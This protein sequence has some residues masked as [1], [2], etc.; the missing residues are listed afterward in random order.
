MILLRKKNYSKSLTT[1]LLLIDGTSFDITASEG[2]LFPA[3]GS[4]SP[5]RAALWDATKNSPLQDTTREIIEV[6]R[7]VDDTFTITL[8]GQEGTAAKEWPIGS[9]FMLTL[10]SGTVEEIEDEIALKADISHSQADSTITLSKIGTP[11]YATADKERD[12]TGS[13][14]VFIGGG[15]TD[16]GNGTITVAAGSGSIRATDALTSAALSVDWAEV[17]SLALDDGVV[18]YIYLEYNA[19][20]PQIVA[21][22]TERTDFNTNI[23]LGTVFR[24]GNTA[25]IYSPK[26]HYGGNHAQQIARRL[27]G[28]L[29]FSRVSG[30][31]LGEIGT[32]NI[33][34]TEGLFWE[35]LDN[36]KTNIGGFDS[37]G[38][39]RFS[40]YYRT[41]AAWT[42]VADQSQIDNVYYNNTAT[43]LV[44]LT[45]NRYGVHWVFLEADSHIIVV[46]GQGDYTLAL[47]QAAKVPAALPPLI[48]VHARLIGKIIIQKAASVFISVESAFIY[49]FEKA[50]AA[51]HNDLLNI[52]GGSADERYH[53]T[54]AQATIATQAAS[55]S[56]SGYL[57]S[58]DWNTFNSKAA[59]LSGTINEIAYFNSATTIASL[60]VATYPSLTELSYVKG[61]SSAI[62]T[63][64]GTK[65]A[66]ITFGTGVLT[67]LGVNVGSAG[68]PVLFNGA[69]G[70]PSSGTLTNCTALPIAGLTASTSTALGVGSLE[71]GHASDTTLSR[72]AAGV[73][74]VEGVVI[75]SISSTNTLTNKRITAREQ[76]EASSATPTPTSDSAD[77]YTL[78]ALAANA[79]F[80]APTGTPTQGQK[81]I[82]RILDNGTARTLG[83]NAIYVSRGATLP[84]TTVISKYLY[85]GLIYNSTASKWDCVAVSSEA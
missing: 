55:T 62:Q 13:A 36:F 3:T 45:T 1:T 10:T 54:A 46:Y 59:A 38:A 66:T 72:S 31:M 53:M 81:L 16:N 75:P 26:R 7:N 65:Q 47:A 83:W 85:V 63:Q 23:F 12:I 19:G 34:I 18:S 42:K 44:E 48:A 27:Q 61:V 80:A 2:A 4:G 28:T 20:T 29:P 40:Y 52:Q 6:Y 11:T 50:T 24:E 21:S 33:S 69:L 70:T 84:T 71:L 41:G 67:A 60:A 15:F 9:Q 8:R 77:I 5:F 51:D 78:T 57:T 17:A 49:A 14:V 25:H 64:L 56:L 73:L 82:I 37:S 32:R 74:A 39:S 76:T 43:G 30:G 79:T 68:A 35:G 22:L 58:T